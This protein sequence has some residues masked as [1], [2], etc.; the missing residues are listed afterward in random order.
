[1]FF[2]VLCQHSNSKEKHIYR[3]VNEDIFYLIDRLKSLSSNLLRLYT[4][5]LIMFNPQKA[6]VIW[7]KS[8]CW[9]I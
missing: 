2:R 6:N 7:H 3:L 9:E 4:P 8:L 1:M 5:G